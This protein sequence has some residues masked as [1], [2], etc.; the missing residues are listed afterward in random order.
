MARKKICIIVTLLVL[1]L[2][3]TLEVSAATCKHEWGPWKITKQATCTGQGSKVHSCKKCGEKW[4]TTISPKGHSWKK[5]V[6]WNRTCTGK[7]LIRYTCTRCGKTRTESP[8]ALGHHYSVYRNF[9]KTRK[10]AFKKTQY[11][12]ELC[13][14]RCGR[15]AGYGGVWSTSKPKDR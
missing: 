5:E 6:V 4:Y 7:G 1:V 9:G 13:C 3:T 10:Q 14:F 12:W 2:A 8:A 15:K 11:Y